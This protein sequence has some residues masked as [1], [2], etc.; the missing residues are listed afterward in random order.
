[1]AHAAHRKTAP[2]KEDAVSLLKSDHEEVAK[3]F[4]KY[5]AGKLSTPDKAALAKQICDALMIHTQIEEEIFYPAC[6][7]QM[8]DVDDLL[9]EAKVE[10]QSLRELIAK[11]EQDKP[12]SEE[13]D[14]QVKVLGEYVTHH[15]EEEHK[16]LFPKARKSKMDL[17]AIGE[18]LAARK[19]ELETTL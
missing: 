3:L 1:M 15:V 7:A 17:Q 11:I 13:Y 16:E 12:G 18:K 14:A 19:E 4:K 2:R 6:H 10:H 5:E 8:R 9:S